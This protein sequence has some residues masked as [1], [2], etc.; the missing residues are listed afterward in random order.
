[1]SIVAAIVTAHRGQVD[2]RPTPGGGAT[3]SVTIPLA[4]PEEKPA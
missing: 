4:P 2:H 3:F 1:L